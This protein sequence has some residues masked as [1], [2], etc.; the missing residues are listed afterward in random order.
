MSNY[1]LRL[2]DTVMT[3]A[4]S[5][6]ERNGTSLNQ[7]LSALIAQR[8]GELKALEH[9]ERRIARADRAAALEVL[10]RVPARTPLPG[11]ELPPGWE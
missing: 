3:D 5:L 8:V 6:A 1:P 10:S 9:F 2:P 7:F 4:K 11:D